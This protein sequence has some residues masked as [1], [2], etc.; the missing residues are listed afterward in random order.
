MSAQDFRVIIVGGSVTGLALALMLE[1]HGIDFIVLEAY[2]SIA[3][4]VG[5][6]IGILPN[7]L[8]VLDQLGCYEDLLKRA[9]YPVNTVSLRDSSGKPLIQVQDVDSQ[10]IGRH[11]YPMIFF[12]RQMLIQILY[13]HIQG[14]NNVL[15]S[16]RVKSIHEDDQGVSVET[17]DGR[18][19]AGHVVVGTD[20]VHSV[21]RKE[22]WRTESERGLVKRQVLEDDIQAKYGCIFGI[23][24][25]I[26]GLP[27]GLLQFTAGQRTSILTASGP[28]DD[29]YWALFYDL[30]ET[31]HGAGSPRLGK[32]DE[33]DVIAKHQNDAVTE[34]MT[35]AD[36]YSSKT[37]SVCTPLHEY[38]VQAWHSQRS[39][40]IGDAA[41]KF[42]PIT[43][44]GGNSAIE[45][46]AA[47][48]NEIVKLLQ[49]Y[50]HTFPP[51]LNFG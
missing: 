17:Q 9:Q 13:D 11:G 40:I 5:A 33:H 27:K 7:G 42:N 44:Q 43:G 20:G 50:V 4:Q 21:V 12:Q 51:S 28:E 38:V 16:T 26:T 36:L 39:I 37:V 35:L 25:G 49:S 10:S 15:T 31:Y 46:A 1:K 29:T 41:H 3:P 19:F 30:G 48:T 32:V 8:R 14:K 6:S 34:E 47:L 18:T 23:S 45:S 2:P 24:T 22:I